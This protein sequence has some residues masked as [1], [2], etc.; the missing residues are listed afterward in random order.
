LIACTKVFNDVFLC[1]NC[2]FEI[3]Q[4]LN[5]KTNHTLQLQQCNSLD[6]VM[7]QDVYKK[8]FARVLSFQMERRLEIAC[9]LLVKKKFVTFSSKP[10]FKKLASFVLGLGGT[11]GTHS[12]EGANG[13]RKKTWW[14]SC[15]SFGSA[16]IRQLWWQ[17]FF[18]H[19]LSRSKVKHVFSW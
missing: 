3:R 2:T 6:R 10:F 18:K 19:F 7:R 5:L 14:K 16:R 13:T 12:L 1:K 15:C 11:N 8:S 9:R 4:L 17:S